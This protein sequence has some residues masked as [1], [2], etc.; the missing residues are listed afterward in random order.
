MKALES[1]TASFEAHG[2]EPGKMFGM[3]VLKLKGKAFAGVF[4]DTL[5][6]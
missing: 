4:D 3:S 5:V 6:F 1:L 2:V